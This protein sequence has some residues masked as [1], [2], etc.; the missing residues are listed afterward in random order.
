MRALAAKVCFVAST[1][2]PLA[3]QMATSQSI[4]QKNPHPMNDIPVTLSSGTVVRI[5]NVVVFQSENESGGLTLYIQTPTAASDTNKVASEA[6]E[7]AALQL[8]SVARAS[9]STVSVAVCRTQACL[10]M[11]EIPKEMFSFTR[12]PDGS[13]KSEKVPE[14]R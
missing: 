9:M 6:K 3:S 7:V 1:L 12:Q 8:K 5:R 2:I 11:H 10:E 14:P 13:L 4:T